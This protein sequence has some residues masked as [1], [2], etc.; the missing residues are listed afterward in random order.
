MNGDIYGY[1]YITTNHITYKRYIGQHKGSQLDQKYLGSGKLMKQA[2]KK[3]G[4]NNFSCKIIDVAY[5]SEELDLK[6]MY[7]IGFYD[8]VNSSRYYNIAA[9][10]AIQGREFG[11]EVSRETREKLR[12]ANTGK[13]LSYETR[14]RMS[15]SQRGKH[16]G[17][18]NSAKLPQSRA[19]LKERNHGRNN[20]A[21]GKHWY[22]NG[23]NAVFAYSCPD[24]YREGR[25]NFGTN[26][27]KLIGR[28]WYNNGI[29]SVL[30]YERPDGYVDGGLCSE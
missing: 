3:Y 9:G 11:H 15:V 1:I 16:C 5:S 7:W 18:K 10:G 28:H 6:E 23:K 2:I 20:P 13:H 30:A 8:A 22:N 26:R 12:I 17:D 27:D 14:L 19:K 21:Y 25:G 29:T 4:R 24:G